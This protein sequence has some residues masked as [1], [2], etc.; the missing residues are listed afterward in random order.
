MRSPRTVRELR[1][2]EKQSG[3][4]VNQV[5]QVVTMLDART[6]TREEPAVFF[7]RLNVELDLRSVTDV[8]QMDV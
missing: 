3:F 1:F 2:N 5:V 4:R 6:Y 7:Q 8:L